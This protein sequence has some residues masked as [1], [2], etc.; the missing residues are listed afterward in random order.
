MRLLLTRMIRASRLDVQTYEQ[1]EADPSSTTGAVVVVIMASIAAAV[2]SGAR[3]L[4]GM[5]NAIVVLLMTWMVWVG[6]AYFI[7]TRLLPEANTHAYIGEVL[8]TTGFSASPGV[9]RFLGA[10]PG[11][12]LPLFL[13][14]TI[15][16]LLTFVVAVR[17][18]L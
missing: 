3:D 9:L 10:L 7:G 2:G 5:G 4:I 6:L 18:A 11:I 8:R 17:Q 1:V 15:W 12:G 14:I 16:M 13:G